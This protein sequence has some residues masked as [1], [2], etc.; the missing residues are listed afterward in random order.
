MRFVEGAPIFAVE[1]RSE[2]DYGA[3]A[4]ADSA[5]K[6]RDYFAADT[7]VVWDVDTRARIVASYHAVAPETPHLFR[8]GDTA[9]AGSALPGWHVAV[10]EL[11]R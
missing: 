10:D 11:F 7:A 5:A 6:R 1:V 4:D 9:D 8:A 2:N 3:T